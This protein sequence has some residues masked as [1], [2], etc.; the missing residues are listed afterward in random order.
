[1]KSFVLFAIQLFAF[2]AAVFLPMMLE[3]LTQNK[4]VLPSRF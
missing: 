3:S 4:S 2:Q 1:M